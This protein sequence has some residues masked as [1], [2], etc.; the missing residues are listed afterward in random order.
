[1]LPTRL[2]SGIIRPERNW[3]RHALVNRRSFSRSNSS[4][5]ASARSKTWMT[6]CPAKSSSTMPFT[7][8]QDLLLLAEVAL[9]EVHDHAHDEHGRPAA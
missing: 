5:Q 2:M 9:R 7:D 8:A 6:P 1:M 4:T 3:L